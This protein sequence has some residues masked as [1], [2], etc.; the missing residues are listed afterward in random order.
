[1]LSNTEDKRFEYKAL[2][3]E[4]PKKMAWKIMDK[5]RPFICGILNDGGQGIIYF[6]IGDSYDPTTKYKR[7]EIIGLEVEDLRDEIN[8]AFQSTLDDHIKSDNGNMTKGGD[9][10]CVNIHFVPVWETEAPQFDK[11][12]RRYVIEIQVERDWRFCE[13]YVYY[14][15]KWTE[16][17]PKER[18]KLHILA[19]LFNTILKNFFMLWYE[20]YQINTDKDRVHEFGAQD[21]Y[22]LRLCVQLHNMSE[23]HSSWKI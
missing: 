20:W 1:M 23:K 18:G 7:G 19:I 10:N 2:T 12:A 21:I 3:Q 6:G 11:P 5:A 14:F 8:K 4:N 17:R 22:A 9:M 16:K 15:Q 13:D